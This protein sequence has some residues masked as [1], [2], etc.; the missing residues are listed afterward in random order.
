MNINVLGAP[1][2]KTWDKRMLEVGWGPLGP[3]GLCSLGLRLLTCVHPKSAHGLLATGCSGNR[4][5]SPTLVPLLF[6]KLPEDRT[7]SPSAGCELRKC[8]GIH[9]HS[10]RVQLYISLCVG[11]TPAFP[12]P[13]AS[14]RPGEGESHLPWTCWR[15][16]PL[17]VS[18]CP[19]LWTSC[20]WLIAAGVLLSVVYFCSAM[21]VA[22]G[23]VPPKLS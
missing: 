15:L 7:L 10:C 4:Y 17:Q 9:E 8:H 2:P 11:S 22:T 13:R 3:R 19:A 18:S 21:A 12:L 6:G 5:S 20:L 14:R 16:L 1:A 23:R